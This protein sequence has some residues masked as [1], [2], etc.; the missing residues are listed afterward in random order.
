MCRGGVGGFA[1]ISC[2]SFLV[3]VLS[4][5]STARS[6]GH[7]LWPWVVQHSL[8]WRKTR[9][10]SSCLSERAVGMDK[11]WYFDSGYRLYNLVMTEGSDNSPKTKRGS[12]EP[13]QP[14]LH[15]TPDFSW[16]AA[17]PNEI[18]GLTYMWTPHG[19]TDSA[20]E[21]IQLSR[22]SLSRK[23]AHMNMVPHVLR[24]AEHCSR[25]T[26]KQWM[27]SQHKNISPS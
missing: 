7:E 27:Y 3:F 1:P 12:F 25:C 17:S 18:P 9:G 11:Y 10:H 26:C 2:I 20:D 5:G 14:P 6:V 24:T 21:C 16:T 4:F 15:N 13:L 22:T 23:Y 8:Q 19:N